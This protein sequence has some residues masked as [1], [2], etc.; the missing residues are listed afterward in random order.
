[1]SFIGVIDSGV[2]GL[3]ILKQLR[4]AHPY[5]YCYIAD[6][7]F[8]PYGAKPNGVLLD[9]ANKLVGYLSSLGAKAV[10]IACNTLSAY[11]GQLKSVYKN[12]PIYDVITPTC[13]KVLTLNPQ[14]KRVALLATKSTIYNGVY[15]TVLK[16]HGVQV[17]GF[18]CSNFV[19]YV[20]QG[21]T[22]TL[23][24]LNTVDIVLHT[25]PRSHVDAVILG[26]THFPL[27]R[28]Q[29]AYYCNDS[30]IVECCCPLPDELFASPS[31]NQCTTY[32][33]TGDVA[34]AK[35]AAKWYCDIDFTH[36]SL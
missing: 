26:C 20:E 30:K 8:C 34:F 23:S 11:T 14:V 22:T 2:G 9:R 3:T 35:S 4:Q 1:M 28:R 33:T 18:D 32:L 15:H 13:Q 19:P 6:H 10:V 12:M 17:V 5:N 25:L 31:N 29:I 36:I 16:E 27:L 24:C 21:T 7:A